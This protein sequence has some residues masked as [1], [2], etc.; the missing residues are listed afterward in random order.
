[1]VRL[2]RLKNTLE[3]VLTCGVSEAVVS[4]LM[5]SKRRMGRVVEHRDRRETNRATSRFSPLAV[6][7][8]FT[9]V[10]YPV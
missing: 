6:R 3:K 7:T 10:Y 2:K 8:H 9:F 4:A 1:M 5:I